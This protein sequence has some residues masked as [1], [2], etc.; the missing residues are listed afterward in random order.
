MDLDDE[1]RCWR[2][3]HPSLLEGEFAKLDAFI[4]TTKDKRQLSVGHS[5]KATAHACFD[6]YVTRL[7]SI[8]VAQ[9]APSDIAEAATREG[10]AVSLMD[11]SA[12]PG[13]PA[14]HCYVDYAQ[15]EARAKRKAVAQHLWLAARSAGW[16]HLP[17]PAIETIGSG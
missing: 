8:G 1:H 4:P 2:Q 17:S 6:D 11:D 15:I 5:S 12:L 9:F 16:A 14:W 3:V 13:R 10:V 7:R